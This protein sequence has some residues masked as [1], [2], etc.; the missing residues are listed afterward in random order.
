[1]CVCVCVC[2]CVLDCTIENYIYMYIM[3]GMFIN[4]E[5]AHSAVMVEYADGFSAAG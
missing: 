5:F 2:V 1:M 3:F 4:K